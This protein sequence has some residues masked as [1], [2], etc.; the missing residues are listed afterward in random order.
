MLEIER[1]ASVAVGGNSG[2]V[3]RTERGE[4]VGVEEGMRGRVG[5]DVEMGV[6]VEGR[7]GM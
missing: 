2:G 6:E 5:V 3:G 1:G 4:A 7:V